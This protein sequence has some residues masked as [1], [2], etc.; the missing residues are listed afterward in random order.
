MMG[1]TMNNIKK[2]I[3]YAI[4]EEGSILETE[5]MWASLWR[6][7][8]RGINW[9]KEGQ[10][11]LFPGRWAIGYNTMYVLARSLNAVKPQNVLELGLGNS[12]Q[13][14]TAYFKSTNLNNVSHIIVEHNEDWVKFYK[15]ENELL[16]TSEV[17]VCPIHKQNYKG[18]RNIWSYVDFQSCVSGKQYDL[19]LIDGPYGSGAKFS[20]IDI[21][22]IIPE[23]LDDSFAII[24]DD[25]ERAGEKNMV[26][27]LEYL[28]QKNNIAYKKG[29]Y[30]GEKECCVI[31][32]EDNA[33]LTSL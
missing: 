2:K 17:C 26:K 22:S 20:R 10:L 12:T 9:L 5:L 18:I 16:D 8:S 25:Y 28:L 27:E 14:I 31:V 4:F 3:R 15:N 13:I 30:P 24:I 21:L 7:A 6:E 19:I 33:F 32:S 11:M 1:K 29:V 23:N